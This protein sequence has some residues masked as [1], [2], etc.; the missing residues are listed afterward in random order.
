MISSQDKEKFKFEFSGFYKLK[1][2]IDYI[3]EITDVYHYEYENLI[4]DVYYRKNKDKLD[5]KKI[6]RVLL[7]CHKIANQKKVFKI[8]LFLTPAK[9]LIETRKIL[10]AVNANSGFT[11]PA[12]NEIYIFREEEYPKVLLHELIHHIELVDKQNFKESNIIA[13]RKKFEITDDTT[14]ILNETIVELWALLL[15]LSFISCEYKLDFNELFNLELKYSLY[16]TYQ[17]LKLKERYKDKKWCDKCN[18]YSYIVFKTIIMMNIQEFLN[19]INSYPYDDT[20]VANFIIQKSGSLPSINSKTRPIN[21]KFKD[22]QRPSNSLC[23][24]LL[25]DL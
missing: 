20:K 25:S 1:E 24:M 9:K 6:H 23:F 12:R 17:I 8:K 3:D 19:K 16:K 13:L 10:T 7:R 5:I 11:Y 14:L 4:I 18:I 21:P 22:F 2:V 15:H